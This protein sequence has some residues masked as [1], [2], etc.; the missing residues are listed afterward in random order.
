[1][2]GN[3]HA[4]IGR[5]ELPRRIGRGCRVGRQRSRAQVRRRRRRTAPPLKVIDFHN[6]YVGPSFALTTMSDARRR[7]CRRARPGS[8][9]SSPIRARSSARSR[10][11]ASQRAS[12]IRRPP[13]C[14][15]PTAKCRRAPSRASTTRSPRWSAR[16]PASSTVSRRWTPISGD[17]GAR[18]LT[19]AV[20]ELSLRGVFI[21]SAKSDLLPNAPQARPTLA[22]AAELGVPVFVHPITDPTDAQALR[23]DRP[24]GRAAR[25]RDHQFAGAAVAARRRRVRRVA[26][27][28]GRGHDAGDRRRADG[29]RLRRR[30]TDPARHARGSRAAMSISTPWACIRRWSAASSSCSAPTTCSPAPTG[31]SSSRRTCPARLQKALTFAGLNAEQ[32]QMVAGG[33]ALKLLGIA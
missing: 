18:E 26:E 30:A 29:R 9:R 4:S 5:R 10:S 14:R 16:I 7:R 2:T 31:R 17:D 3:G 11:P 20:R 33:N 22:A 24:P 15:T 23:A 8:T 21:E 13:S 27:A 1:M 25:A 28:E 32:Q 12:S 6:H 19:R